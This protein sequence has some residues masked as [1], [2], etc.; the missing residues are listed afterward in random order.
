M[1]LDC[2]INCLCFRKRN[3]N[4]SVKLNSMTVK[5]SS[6]SWKI[7]V[8]GFLIFALRYKEALAYQGLT[9][10]VNFRSSGKG[11][12]DSCELAPK[13]FHF[14]DDSA[15]IFHHQSYLKLCNSDCGWLLTHSVEVGHYHLTHMKGHWNFTEVPIH[16]ISSHCL[17]SSPGAAFPRHRCIH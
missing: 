7:F 16:K 4:A 8:E 6:L 15:A 14:S 3:V 12:T 2:L 9:H 13:V 11:F 5:R 17:P 10:S 1:D